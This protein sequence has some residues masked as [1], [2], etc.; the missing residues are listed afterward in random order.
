MALCVES[1]LSMA[2]REGGYQYDSETSR[3]G[4]P[5]IGHADTLKVLKE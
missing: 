3:R 4:A 5:R 1:A 2:G